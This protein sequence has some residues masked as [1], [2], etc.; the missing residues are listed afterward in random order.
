MHDYN[1]KQLKRESLDGDARVGA[2]V[3]EE[4]ELTSG[5]AQVVE[6][7][8]TM[9]VGKVIDGLQLED[10]LIIAENIGNV[11][12]LNGFALVEDRKLS[13]GF[14]RDAARR[15]LLFK[16]LLIDLFLPGVAHL[17]VNLENRALNGVDLVFE[18][19][20]VV[21]TD[22][23]PFSCL[24]VELSC[25]GSGRNPTSGRVKALRLWRSSL[26]ET[27][28]R[29]GALIRQSRCA[30]RQAFVCRAVRRR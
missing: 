28:H 4:A 25:L 30:T 5:D 18:K 24:F 9:F 7:L 2:E 17:A 15:E 23:I 8:T 29:R 20:L 6:N 19:Q 11:G 1:R 3:Y 12:L 10:D 26:L 13:F 22:I 21:H 14:E 16:T 27:A